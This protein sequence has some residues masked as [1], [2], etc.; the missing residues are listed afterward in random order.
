MLRIRPP[1]LDRA[2]TAQVCMTPYR[3]H[4]NPAHYHPCPYSP[5]HST[6]PPLVGLVPSIYP[7][8]QHYMPWR[9]GRSAFQTFLEGNEHSCSGSQSKWTRLRFLV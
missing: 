6:V 2:H 7:S 3:P 9:L 8:L 5:C 4:D 1:L